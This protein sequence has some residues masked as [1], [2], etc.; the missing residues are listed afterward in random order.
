MLGRN[1]GMYLFSKLCKNLLHVWLKYI[2]EHSRLKIKNITNHKIKITR[3]RIFVRLG[4]V[5]VHGRITDEGL[6]FS[7]VNFLFP[8]RTFHPLDFSLLAL[9]KYLCVPTYSDMQTI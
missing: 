2:E 4:P 1:I 5:V 3:V 8:G 7:D 9:I 6:P